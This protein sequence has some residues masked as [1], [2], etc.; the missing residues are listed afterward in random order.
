MLATPAKTP[1]TGPEWIH[2][3]KFDGFRAQVHLEGEDIAIYSRNG[4]DLTRRF[5]KLQ[6]TL[7]SFPA[8]SAI[9]DCELV[10]CDES[11]Q[12]DFQRLMREGGKANGLCLVCFDLLALNGERLTARALEERR[13]KLNALIIGADDQGL[14]FSSAFEDPARLLASA[15]KMA[16]EGIVSKRRDSPYVSGRARQWVKV[17]TEAWKTSTA[18]RCNFFKG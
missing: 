8:Q 1:P 18:E 15:E 14:H 5:R 11:G 2:E 9:L 16:L 7:S 10:A 13:S 4:Q 12:P 6:D 3:V 17:K